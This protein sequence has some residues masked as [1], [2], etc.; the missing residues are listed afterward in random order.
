RRVAGRA[1]RHHPG[2]LRTFE[3]RH[4]PAFDREAGIAARLVPEARPEAEHIAIE[5]EARGEVIDE[6]SRLADLHGTSLGIKSTNLHEYPHS[7]GA[8]E[9]MFPHRAHF[10]AA[11]R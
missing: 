2:L 5:A 7:F 1:Q 4:R 8:G 6:Q 11:V 9:T 10:F 3:E